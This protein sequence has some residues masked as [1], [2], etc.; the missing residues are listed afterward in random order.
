MAMR[1]LEAEMSD[2]DEDDEQGRDHAA[3][4][5]DAA[6]EASVAQGAMDQTG[7]RAMRDGVNAR[8]VD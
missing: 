7:W 1:G 4:D 3:V 6:T 8:K 2:R 5:G